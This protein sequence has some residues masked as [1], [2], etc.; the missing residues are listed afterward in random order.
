MTIPKHAWMIRAGND[1]VL[2]DRVWDLNAVA[3]GWPEMGD[4]SSFKTRDAFK[5]RY[6]QVY[7]DDAAGSIPVNAG[8]L[9]RFV[10]EIQ[11]GDYL[12]TYIQSTR[13][14]LIGI[15]ESPYRYD[16]ALFSESYP[17]VRSVKWQKRISRDEFSAPARNSM[18][19]VLTVFNLDNHFEEIHAL[20]TGRKEEKVIAEATASP[21]FFEDVKSQ[22]DELISDLISKLDP[23]QFQNLV[24]AVL[25]AMGFRAASTKPGRDRGI[26]IVAYRDALGFEEPRIEAQVKHRQNQKVTGPDMRSFIGSLHSANRG[27]FVSTSGFTDDAKDAARHAPVAITILDRDGFIELMLEYYEALEPEFRALIPLHKIWVPVK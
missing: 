22:A 19:S 14:V 7:Q 10:C 3:I 23:Y 8:Q 24:A 20:A 13:E 16:Q 9:F 17:Q 15:V 11:E 26:D 4:L 1:N 12:L 25:R 2:A 6:A 5:K 18:G 21:P 27:L